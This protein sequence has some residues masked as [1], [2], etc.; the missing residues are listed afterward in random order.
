[1]EV[2]RNPKADDCYQPRS[3]RVHSPLLSF[4]LSIE[5]AQLLCSRS[6][7]G[8]LERPELLEVELFPLCRLWEGV[9]GKGSLKFDRFCPSSRLITHTQ[10]LIVSPTA[11]LP[12]EAVDGRR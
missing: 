7:C 9:V 10:P 11:A 4:Q 12:A 2:V 3:L 8:Y 5:L 6:Y 1:M